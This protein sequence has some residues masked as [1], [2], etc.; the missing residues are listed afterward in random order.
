MKKEV[1]KKEVK[2]TVFSLDDYAGKSEELISVLQK[3]QHE[4]HY[5]SKESL[6]KVARKLNVPFSKVYGVAT[7]YS[8]FK[9]SKCAK[10]Q[11]VVCNGTACHVRGAD[12]LVAEVKKQ[13]GIESGQMTSDGLF[14]LEIVR[15]LGLCAS[16]PVM[17]VNDEVHPKISVKDV[18]DIL[19]SYRN[20]K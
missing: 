10:Y 1:V 5:L 2:S 15:C 8:F 3:I 16:A 7:F 13:L 9:L 19:D 14:S 12:S 6:A 11:I 20:K 17:K 18:K 4:E